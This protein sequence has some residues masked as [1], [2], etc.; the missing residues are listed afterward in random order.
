LGWIT[1]GGIAAFFFG[2]IIQ[3]LWNRIVVG[4]LELLKPLSYLQAAGLW[5][6][7]ALLF[8][9]VGARAS[10]RRWRH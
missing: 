5:F 4:H 6:L 7:I 2:W 10:W 3:M 8:A 1:G 9:W